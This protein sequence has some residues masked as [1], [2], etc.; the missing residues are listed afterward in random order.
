MD[1]PQS[2]HR[3]RSKWPV[4]LVW[5]V[6]LGGVGFGAFSYWKRWEEKR[7]IMRFGPI[8]MPSRV[9]RVPN[10]WSA[11]TLALR[12]QKAGKV[13][14]ASAFEEVADEIGL[15]NVQKGIYALPRSASPR[16]LAKIFKAGPTLGRVTF[17]EGFTGFQ[18][19]ARLKKNGFVNADAFRTLVYPPGKLSP[20]EGTLFPQTYD[21]PLNGN[22][23]SLTARLQRQFEK[24]LKGL[25]RPFPQVK[26][27]V[28]T[29]V[30][31]ITMASLIEREAASREEMPTVAGVILN[32]LNA[33]MRLQIDAAILYARVL[34]GK[35]SKKRMTYA[36]YKFKSPYNTYLSAG[37][38]P[39]PICNP[40]ADALKAA[41][42]PAKT[43]ALYYVLSP[44]LK[45]HRFA[46]SYSEHLK[47][48]RLAE[49]ERAAM[50]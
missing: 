7:H 21:L 37:L 4:F 17:P 29:T 9:A 5:L 12:L 30:Q 18:M 34:E 47:N 28:L 44:L 22:A 39:G 35:G 3:P 8:P 25:P 15:Q 2:L 13:R 10:D 32:R 31:V 27:K 36:D 50:P 40:G 38:P 33:P 49:K 41:A 16:D 48:V 24:T 42:H 43:N 11:E 1:S 26:G 45:R 6:I 23:K 14:D 19:A 46:S 20:Y